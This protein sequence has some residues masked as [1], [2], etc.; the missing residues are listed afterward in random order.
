MPNVSAANN[1]GN[2]RFVVSFL[3]TG[4]SV[5]VDPPAGHGGDG[6]S[7]APTDLVDAAL[8]SCTGAMIFNKAKSMGIDAGGMK[9]TSSHTMADAPRRIGSIEVEVVLPFS[10]DDRQKKSLIAAAKGCPVRNSLNTNMAVRETFLWADGS[11]DAV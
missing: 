9:L 3:P 10:V 8:L 6:T 4:Q 7:F 5:L 11:K 2:A 1:E